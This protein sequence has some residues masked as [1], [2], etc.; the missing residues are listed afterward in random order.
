MRRG[1]DPTAIRSPTRLTPLG[2]ATTSRSRRG[3]RCLAGHGDRR[4]ALSCNILI[5][6]PRSSRPNFSVE[7]RRQPGR[8]PGQ[9]AGEGTWRW[10]A[11]HRTASNR[12]L[13]ARWEGEQSELGR[14]AARRMPPSAPRPSSG[15]S[16]GGSATLEKPLPNQN[17]RDR[18]SPGLQYRRSHH[19]LRRRFP[20]MGMTTRPY[21]RESWCCATQKRN[22][23][24]AVRPASDLPTHILG[25]GIQPPT[26]TSSPPRGDCARVPIARP[27]VTLWDPETGHR[28]VHSA[29]ARGFF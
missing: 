10:K 7:T 19:G 6:L 9:R 29:R 17:T 21:R 26:V 8:G 13:I 20:M 24:R 18:P 12:G 28:A 23:G 4:A 14:A 27:E 5:G 2:A 15:G 16:S 3:D 22:R 1:L 25:S 11:L